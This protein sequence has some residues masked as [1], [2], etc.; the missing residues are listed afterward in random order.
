MFKAQILHRVVILCIFYPMLSLALCI[1]Y[2]VVAA[3]TLGMISNQWND[4]ADTKGSQ[5]QG[6]TLDNLRIGCKKHFCIHDSNSDW[7]N[8]AWDE[9]ALMFL[10]PILCPITNL[11]WIGLLWARRENKLKQD[12]AKPPFKSP[13][14][15]W[16]SLVSADNRIGQ[17]LT[18]LFNQFA[19]Y[20]ISLRNQ[21]WIDNSKAHY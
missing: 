13:L 16:P 19:I 8:P 9:T 21:R 12:K 17:I 1:I 6:Q 4:W 15:I 3:P 10:I 14:R 2:C 20:H 7:G 11:F 5:G 18:V